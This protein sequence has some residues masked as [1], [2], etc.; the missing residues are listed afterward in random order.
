MPLLSIIVPVYNEANTIKQILEKMNSTGIDQEII[1]VDDGS[2]DGTDKILRDIRYDNLKLIHHTSNRG[3]GAAFLTGLSLATG[4]FVIIQDADLEYDPRNY[5]ALLS[6]T[7]E[8]RA[9][10]VLGVRFFT[11]YH[12][13]FWHRIGNRALT[14]LLNILF[15]TSLNDAYTCYKLAS[16]DT[17]NSLGLK[18]TGFEID[19]QII[20]NALK[21]KIPILQVPV[22]YH[23]RSYKEGKKIRWFDGLRAI[24]YILK[25]RF[26]N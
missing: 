25:Y 24:Y 1:V 4:E 3:K 7:K 23:P 17:F 15:A 26:L 16:R 18:G 10:L 8:N 22:S 20:C 21:K 6:A 13:L 19:T 2:G 11:G 12:G 5:S 9:S 14:G